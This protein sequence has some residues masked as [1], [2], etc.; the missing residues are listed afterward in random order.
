MDVGSGHDDHTPSGS[1]MPLHW[2]LRHSYMDARGVLCLLQLLRFFSVNL[3]STAI[4]FQTIMYSNNHKR[5]SVIIIIYN[6][7]RL[8][9]EVA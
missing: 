5:C 3:K 6:Q 9:G 8:S 2:Q 7:I 4:N 1:A